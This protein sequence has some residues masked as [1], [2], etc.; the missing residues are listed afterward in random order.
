MNIPLF[1][2][3]ETIPLHQDVEGGHGESQPSPEVVPD[4][5]GEFLEMADQSE[6]RKHGFY[7][8]TLIPFSSS[9]E[10]EIGGVSCLSMKSAVRQNDHLVLEP[11]GQGLEAGVAGIGSSADQAQ[12]VERQAQLAPHD[13]AIIG[14]ALLPQLTRRPPFS[15]GV[16]QLNAV[17]IHHSQ[18][19]GGSQEPVGPGLLGPEQPEETSTMGQLGKQ[20]LVVVG[21]PAIESPGAHA[22]DGVEQPDSDRLTGPQPGLGMLGYLGHLVVHL[23]K[24]LSDKIYGGHGVAPSLMFVHH[25]L[26]TTP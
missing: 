13:P 6:H 7:H 20:G 12:M 1:I 26:E 17:A 9:A 14:L 24:Q 15:D 2:G 3:L 10:L 21:Q 5:M 19:R 25:Q 11:L 4:P 16:K 22:F 8:H 18:Q 23:T